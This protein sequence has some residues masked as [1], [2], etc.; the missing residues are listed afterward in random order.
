MKT[1]LI[2][3]GAWCGLAVFLAAV[4]SFLKRH[5]RR[6]DRRDNDQ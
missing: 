1:I 5:D 6:A 4:F 3:L 2:A